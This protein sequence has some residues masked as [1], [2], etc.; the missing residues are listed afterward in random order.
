V[1]GRLAGDEE[2]AVLILSH[3]KVLPPLAERIAATLKVPALRRALSKPGLSPAARS[4]IQK[5]LVR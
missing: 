1:E 2:L 5:R 3:A 4:A